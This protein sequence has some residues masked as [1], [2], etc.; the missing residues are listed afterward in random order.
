MEELEKEFDKIKIQCDIEESDEKKNEQ[1]S[2]E[3]EEEYDEEDDNEE[4]KKKEKISQK[5]LRYLKMKDKKEEKKKKKQNSKMNNKNEDESSNKKDN[6][7]NNKE[8]VNN[9]N[10]NNNND[11]VSLKDDKHDKYE[12]VIVEY[13]KVCG[14]PY[15]Y[16]EYGNSFNECKEENKDKYNYDALNSNVEV[17]KKQT[18]KPTKNVSQKITIQKTTRAKKKVVTVV[19]GLHPY[20]KLEKMAKIFSKFYACGSSVIKGANNNPDQIDIQGD[21]EHNIVEVIMKNCPEL[22]EDSFSILPSK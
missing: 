2:A 15:E 12:P 6:D 14:M 22:T 9:D 13:C 20:I 17:N 8:H 7:I 3:D 16:C 4:K 18:K 10:S 5:K 1:Q 21:V 11:D 19:T